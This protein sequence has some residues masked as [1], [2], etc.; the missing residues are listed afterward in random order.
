MFGSIFIVRVENIMFVVKCC[1]VFFNL[2]EGGLKVVINFLVFMVS[3][4]VNV[5]SNMVFNMSFFFLV[6]FIEWLFV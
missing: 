4:G 3:R 5:Y 1:I 2:G 6:R